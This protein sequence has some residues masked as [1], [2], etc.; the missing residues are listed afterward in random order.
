MTPEIGTPRI[1]PE[2]LAQARRNPGT[3]LYEIDPAHDPD[4]TVPP[5]AVVGAWQV[6]DRGELGAYTPN[7]RYRPSPT[8]LGRRPPPA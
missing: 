2:L 5:Y 3:W 1:T 6:D 4:G 8:A 7:P